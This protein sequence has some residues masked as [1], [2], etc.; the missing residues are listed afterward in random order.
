MATSKKKN[1]APLT[2]N[3]ASHIAEDRKE[4][5]EAAGEAASVSGTVTI[6]LNFPRG[7]DFDFEDSRG[8]KKVLHVNGNAVNLRG[9][10]MGRLPEG[11]TYG[12]TFGVP[13]EDWAAVSEK[14]R[15]MP[16][17]RSGLI[18]AVGTPAEA[19][20]EA[21]SRRDMRHGFEP[22]DTTKSRT[23]PDAKE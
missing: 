6:A 16:L 21:A 7:V 5:A 1:A 19:K 12:L 15:N 13:A 14:Y 17:F 9:L 2:A 8:A 11:G 10:D 23:Q 3:D 22:I 20:K 4:R 18:F